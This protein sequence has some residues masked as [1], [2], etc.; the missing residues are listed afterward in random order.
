IIVNK[1][2]YT[3]SSYYFLAIGDESGKR[4]LEKQ[5]G[6]TNADKISS[7][8]DYIFHEADLYNILS[9]G[10]EWFEERFT[11]GSSVQFQ[12][13]L[14][15]LVPG[16]ITTIEANVMSA[17]ASPSTFSL[18][19]NNKHLGDI[20]MEAIPRVNTVTGQN[21]YAIKGNENYKVFSET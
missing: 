14:P 17:N 5:S 3:D 20:S 13:D 18:N 21:T 4:I 19:A 8:K 6:S 2:L 7:Y 12:F 1:N 9:S 10:R 11:A 15:D 16:S